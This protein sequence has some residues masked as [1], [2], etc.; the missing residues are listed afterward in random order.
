MAQRSSGAS[1]RAATLLARPVVPLPE[2][3]P[4]APL[5]GRQLLRFEL[6]RQLVPAGRRRM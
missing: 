3:V 5:L 2:R 4:D 6:E 1:H